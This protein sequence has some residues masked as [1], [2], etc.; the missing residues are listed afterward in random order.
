MDVAPHPHIGLQTV[1]W[2]LDGEVL[3]RDSLGYESLIRPGELNLM[4]SGR[5][6]AHSEETPRHH[7]GRLRGVQLWVA[8]P[9][10]ARNAAAGFAHHA[11]IPTVDLA[12]G[13]AKVF[14]GG[15]SPAAFHSPIVGA[16]IRVKRALV[17]P[18]EREFEHALFVLDGAATLDGEPLEREVLYY[19]APGTSELPL[20]TAD[21]A[22]I[23]LLGG[24]PFEERIV[25]WW[26]FVART[27]EEIV[28]AREE[29]ERGESRFGEVRG[30]HGDRIPAPG[31]RGFAAP[32]P[33][34]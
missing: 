15:P 27:R 19:L 22:T 3:H 8:L 1:S 7:S 26:N 28:A 31:L 2:L 33:A 32:N 20:A 29:W 13:T 21:R 14:A 25:M 12:G 4:T 17:M 18:V 16:E 11:D 5:G 23:L 24:T 30:Y 6:I 34:S 10:A 9:D